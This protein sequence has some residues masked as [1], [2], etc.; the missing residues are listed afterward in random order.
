MSPARVQ[1]V[2]ELA[3]SWVEDG[4]HHALVVLVARRG[5][6]VLHEAFGTLSPEPDSPPLPLDAIFPLASAT[7]PVTAAATMCLVEDGRVGLMRPVR[8]YY[9]EISAEGTE[10]VLVHHLLTH[11]SGWR[12]LDVQPA[13][14]RLLQEGGLPAPEPGQ[15]PLHAG[16]ASLMRTLPLAC[17]PGEAMQYCNINYE[18]LADLT[19]RVSGTPIERFARERIFEPLGM[20][21]SSYVLPP[22]HRE[23]K[24]RRGE[25]MPGS[26]ALGPVNPGIDS[27]QSEGTPSGASG[28]HASARDIAVFAQMLLNGGTYDG[29]RVLSGASVQAMRRNQVPEGVPSIWE[30]LGPDG[31]PMTWRFP[32]SGYGY[33]LFPFLHGVTSYFNGGLAS[34][35]SFGH[36][37]YGGIYFWADPERD[38]VGVYLSV[39]RRNLEDDF[40]PDWRADIFVDAVTAAAED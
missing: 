6:I 17:G 9:P 7:K 39:A 24:V 16:L 4:T 33:G 10:E 22:E 30:R 19:R 31:K 5:L 15:H 20:A 14:E 27:E 26:E 40:T 12:D 2:K 8:E 34:P 13:V 29:Q 18:L 25:G 11:L 38:L 36:S 23:R 32:G 35:S 21:D 1:H 3:R 28:M 37:G